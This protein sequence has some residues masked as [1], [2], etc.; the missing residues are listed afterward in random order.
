MT[1]NK[2]HKQNVKDLQ[3]EGLNEDLGDNE[4][5]ENFTYT[6]RVYSLDEDGDEDD[7]IEEF[8]SLK[9]AKEFALKQSCP[10]HIVYAPAFD[11]DDY[12]PEASNQGEYEDFEV[13]WSSIN[14]SFDDESFDECVNKFIRETYENVDS[15]KTTGGSITDEELIIEGIIKFKSGKEKLTSF[16]FTSNQEVLLEGL[17]ETF[18]KENKFH[19]TYKMDKSNIITEK[20]DYIKE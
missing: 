20:L 18:S 6:F 8:D 19:L 10:T 11:P 5:K 13:V 9:E 3:G 2:E 12:G 4:D 1:K 17:N 15:Y 16:V 7:F 14:E